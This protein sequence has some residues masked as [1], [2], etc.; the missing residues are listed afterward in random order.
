MARRS[1]ESSLN[2]RKLIEALFENDQILVT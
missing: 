2:H 1:V